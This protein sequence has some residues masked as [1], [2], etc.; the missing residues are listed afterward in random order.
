MAADGTAPGYIDTAMSAD[1]S[2]IG[3]PVVRLVISNMVARQDFAMQLQGQQMAEIL[4]GQRSM[5]QT[6]DHMM[7]VMSQISSVHHFEERQHSLQ[8]PFPSVIHADSPVPSSQSSSKSSNQGR[9]SSVGSS[10]DALVC[11]FC[12]VSHYSEKS[13]FQHVDRLGQRIGK[14]YYGDCVFP[15]NHYSLRHFEGASVG[16]KMFAFC[17]Q[18]CS[19]IS[20]SKSSG[21]DKDRAAALASWLSSLQLEP[22]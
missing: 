1:V 10:G 17:R 11:P 3:D 13:H 12:F 16:D 14:L 20:S 2:R 4:T 22:Q 9:S 15:E 6:M 5:K 8:P 21:I 7:D 18:Y 19:K